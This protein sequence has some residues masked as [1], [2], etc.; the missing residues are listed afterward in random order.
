M[1]LEPVWHPLSTVF[2]AEPRC[3]ATPQLVRM[4]LG[5]G[6][7]RIIYAG[8]RMWPTVSHGATIGLSPLDDSP[9][10]PG[11]LLLVSRSGIPDVL[12]VVNRDGSR[13]SLK[14]DAD[15]TSVAATTDDV[16][17]RCRLPG[18]RPS[19]SGRRI[20]RA[21][22]DLHEATRSLDYRQDPARTVLEKYDFQAPFYARSGGPDLDPRLLQRIR[23]RVPLGGKLLVVGSGAG[24]E[25]L[26]LAEQGFRVSGIDF[27]PAMVEQAR[28]AARTRGLDVEFRVADL[29]S[30]DVEPGSIDAVLFTYDVYSF[31][32]LADREPALRRVRS[33]IR[34]GGSV[35]L[36]ARLCGGA[37][38]RTVLSLQWL[39]AIARGAPTPWGAS[40]TRWVG[41][42][43]GLRRSFVQ[44]FPRRSLAAEIRRAGFEAGEW[45]AGHVALTPG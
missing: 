2:L 21:L 45:E 7:T 19:E 9:P 24:K 17:A 12:R 41:D 28:A 1:P 4:L 33:W 26:A 44:V 8:D 23:G 25:S 14:A 39:A 27:S 31:I 38:Q 29:R 13:L 40:H 32:P 43:A 3:L 30:H 36:S 18:K 37:W 34:P 11:E 6:P 15:P 10:E 20:R 42:D 5:A 35:L 22:L 16:L